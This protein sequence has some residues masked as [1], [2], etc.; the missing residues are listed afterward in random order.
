MDDIKV[1]DVIQLDP[2]K[3]DWGA[4]FC[5]VDEV[6]SWGVVCYWLQVDERGQ[7]PDRAYYRASHETYKYIG[8]AE[9]FV[10]SDDG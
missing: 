1:G 5:I 4:I 8:K 3:H 6:K 9:W 2:T 7:V 10:R